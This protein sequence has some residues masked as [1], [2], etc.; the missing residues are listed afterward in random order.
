MIGISFVFSVS[1]TLAERGRY[2]F[3][4][5][6]SVSYSSTDIPFYAST[7]VSHI[8]KSFVACVSVSYD[9]HHYVQFSY[10]VLYLLSEIS[11]LSIQF[12]LTLT[13]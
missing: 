12:N 10:Y 5:Y 2:R 3:V 11:L 8:E 7:S 4:R 1:L 13:D 9:R 6:I